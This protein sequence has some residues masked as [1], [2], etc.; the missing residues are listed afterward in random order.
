MQTEWNGEWWKSRVASI[1]ASL[2]KILFD[3]DKRSEWIYRGTTRLE[4]LFNHLNGR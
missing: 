2:V 3:V 1:D 4:P